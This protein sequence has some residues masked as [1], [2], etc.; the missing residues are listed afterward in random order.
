MTMIAASASALS[1]TETRKLRARVASRISRH[2]TSA[3][4]RSVIGVLHRATD[5]AEEHRGEAAPL[6]R[7]VADRPG[8]A[9]GVED[10]RGPIGHRLRS[11]LPARGQRLSA[12]G[13]R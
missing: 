13:E 11:R 9:G 1:T 3:I 8:G 4:G 12:R 5:G 2:A 7:E 10:G 6:E